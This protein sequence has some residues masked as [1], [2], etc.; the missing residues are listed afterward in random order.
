MEGTATASVEDIRKGTERAFGSRKNTSVK[1]EEPVIA[2]AQI[3]QPVVASET[4]QP[5]AI[6]QPANASQEPSAT[7]VPNFDE[8]SD[9]QRN[10][11]LAKLTKGKIK[12]I[13]DLTPAAPPVQKTREE[14]E[15]EEEEERN[16]AISHAFSSG[17]IKKDDYDR[18]VSTRSKSE[19]EIAFDLFA[20]DVKAFD[21]DLTSEEISLL[22]SE[23]FGENESEG[24][25]KYK[26][27]QAEIQRIAQNHLAQFP[28]AEQMVEDFRMQKK[29]EYNKSQL[30][31]MVDQAFETIS[32]N[33]AFKFKYK[34]ASEADTEVDL[35]YAIDEAD[36]KSI[37]RD[38]KKN[39]VG[40]YTQLGVDI[41]D[42]KE[43]DLLDAI[44]TDLKSKLFDKIVPTIAALAAEKGRMDTEAIHK[45]IPVRTTNF[46]NAST[47]LPTVPAQRQMSD[48]ERRRMPTSR[49]NR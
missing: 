13:E 9:E 29:A 40:F 43:A 27:G 30:G 14:L 2:A 24:S 25:L 38:A 22:F 4:P 34:N 23:Q 41:K 7:M 49:Y 8:L 11:W 45:N 21:K 3:Q 33:M 16:E 18:A 46:A 12:S 32:D 20:S 31:K 28:T 44:N 1:K 19:R 47:Q 39:I 15:R 10:E 48:A 6:T 36:L 26:R 42:V 35:S 5:E 17:K 37:K